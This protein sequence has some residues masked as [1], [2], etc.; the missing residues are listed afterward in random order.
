[1][2]TTHIRSKRELQE[3]QTGTNTSAENTHLLHKEKYPCTADLLFYLLGFSC[4]ANYRFACLVKS[5]QGGQLN[6]LQSIILILFY[7][8]LSGKS[9]QT[10][11]LNWTYTKQ[12]HFSMLEL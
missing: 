4:Y 1:M 7:T 8:F 2:G 6:P 10:F 3:S 11:A 9:K 12:C 5:N